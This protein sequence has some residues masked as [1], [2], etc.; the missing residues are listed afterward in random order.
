MVSN[1]SAVGMTVVYL[2]EELKM[3]ECGQLGA[4]LK[5]GNTPAHCAVAEGRDQQP[6][7]ID[8]TCKSSKKQAPV[9]GTFTVMSTFPKEKVFFF[10]GRKQQHFL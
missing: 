10:F 8:T 9:C 3:A 5:H 4:K 2:Y 1:Q 6:A 7:L